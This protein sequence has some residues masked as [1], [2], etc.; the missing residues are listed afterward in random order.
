MDRIL[1]GMAPAGLAL[2]LALGLAAS[3]CGGYG[4]GHG[5]GSGNGDQLGGASDGPN[6]RGPIT[7][8]DTNAGTS[9]TGR[10]DTASPTDGSRQSADINK[11]ND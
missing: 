6:G 7:T 4:R 9:G 8:N 2:V 11:R 1:K 10:R 5:E 3:G